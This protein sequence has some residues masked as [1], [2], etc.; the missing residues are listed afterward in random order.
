MGSLNLPASGII[1]VDTSPVI[2]S[3]EENS[4]YRQLLEPL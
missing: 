2:Y 3:I 1:Y 4:I